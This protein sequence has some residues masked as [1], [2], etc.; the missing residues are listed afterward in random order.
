MKYQ[1]KCKCGNIKEVECSMQDIS[2]LKVKCNK[3]GEDMKRVWSTSFVV[4]EHMKNEN[5]QEMSYVKN[6]LKTRP[7]GKNKVWY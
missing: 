4:P 2:T 5:T 6:I 7:S 1:F 3:C